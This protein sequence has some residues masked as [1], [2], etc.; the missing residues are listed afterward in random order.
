MQSAARCP[1]AALLRRSSHLASPAVRRVQLPIAAQPS[2]TPARSF[3]TSRTA[4]DELVF[5]LVPAVSGSSPFQHVQAGL[6]RTAMPSFASVEAERTYRKEHLAL[7]FRILHRFGMAEGIAG[8]SLSYSL[9]PECSARAATARADQLASNP[10][11]ATG[12]CSVR[13]PVDP[14]SFWVN[15]Q[16]KSFALMK[17]SNL[18]RC[19][20]DDG[21]ILEGAFPVDASATAIHSQIYKGRGRGPAADG[22]S[23]G[24]VEAL[25]HVHGP[26]TKAFSSLGRE[27]DMISQ[28]ACAY[29]QDQVLIPFGGASASSLAPSCPNLAAR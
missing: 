6:N 21:A 13:D 9:V 4:A 1:A 3:A 11:L 20:V 16:S 18:V 5:P 23:P 19:S 17:V 8:W 25:V 24:G 7:A 29:Y 10:R 2:R 12:H 15:P 14:N 28:D 26:Y 27:L 22:G